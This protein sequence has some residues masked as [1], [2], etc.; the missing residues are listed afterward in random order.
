MLKMGIPRKIKITY[1]DTA[2]NK[3]RPMRPN[4]LPSGTRA[5]EGSACAVAAR[6][7]VSRALFNQRKLTHA[8]N[9]PIRTPVPPR[10]ENNKHAPAAAIAP[11][12]RVRRAMRRS[13]SAYG[14]SSTISIAAPRE[15]PQNVTHARVK[16][17]ATKNKHQNGFGVQPAVKQV[18]ERAAHNDCGNHYKWQFQSESYLMITRIRPSW[19][20]WGDCRNLFIGCH[21]IPS[22]ITESRSGTV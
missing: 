9:A 11:S 19:R 18:A 15:P 6:V 2:S 5:L 13:V 10:I 7:T 20:R 1:T 21:C 22:V 14:A 3:Y 16:T 17:N 8:S 4:T 12:R